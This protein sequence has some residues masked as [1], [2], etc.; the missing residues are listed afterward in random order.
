MEDPDDHRIYIVVVNHQEQYSIWP[1]E[2]AL[3]AGGK[4]ICAR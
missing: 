1:A 4:S 2:K 3:P